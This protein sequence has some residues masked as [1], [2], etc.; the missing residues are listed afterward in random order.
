MPN[1]ITNCING[2]TKITEINEHIKNWHL[3]E[4]T[5]SLYAHLG[6]TEEE[7][8]SWILNTKTLDQIISER[9]IKS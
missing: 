8:R 9:N 5:D 4:S 2:S 6:F 7:Y 3:S 1:F